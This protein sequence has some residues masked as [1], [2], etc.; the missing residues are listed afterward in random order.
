MERSG[1]WRC[2]ASCF[3]GIRGW[4]GMWCRLC[5]VLLLAFCTK[6]EGRRW[7]R[8]NSL[9]KRFTGRFT[10][11]SFVREVKI[12]SQTQLYH[13]DIFFFGTQGLGHAYEVPKRANWLESSASVACSLALLVLVAKCLTRLMAGPGSGEDGGLRTSWFWAAVG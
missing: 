10:P 2:C 11:K 12:Y 6:I 1:V 13:A 7:Q 3:D 5:T 4:Y 8:G 9:P